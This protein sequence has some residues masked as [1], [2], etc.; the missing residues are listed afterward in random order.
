MSRAF[1]EYELDELKAI[2]ESTFTAARVVA[3]SPDGSL[4]TCR[5]LVGQVLQQIF[6]THFGSC[7]VPDAD[8]YVLGLLPDVDAFLWTKEPRHSP[9]KLAE[10]WIAAAQF[11]STGTRCEI[12]EASEADYGFLQG[13]MKERMGTTGEVLGFDE[14]CL[15]VVEYETMHNVRFEEGRLSKVIADATNDYL[16]GC[17]QN[18][19]DSFSERSIDEAERDRWIAGYEASRPAAKRLIEVAKHLKD[20]V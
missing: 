3:M 13:R 6:S 12:P 15:E 17:V 5:R 18:A 2:L 16:D 7:S 8:N 19:H 10:L 20:Q 9:R 14:G 11:E 1:L 4:K